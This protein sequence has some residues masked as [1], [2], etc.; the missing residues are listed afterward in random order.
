MFANG[1]VDWSARLRKVAASSCQAETSAGCI[2]VKRNIFLR[3]FLGYLLDAIGTKL[4]GGATLLL[5]ANSAAVEQAD[6]SGSS[7]KTEHHQRWEFYLRECQLDGL[8]KAHFI[9]T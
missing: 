6:H 5:I 9:C 3:T 7:K 1:S 8:I 2:A 4:N